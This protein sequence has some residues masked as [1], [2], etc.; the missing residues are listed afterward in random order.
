[1]N[2]MLTLWVAYLSRRTKCQLT[3]KLGWIRLLEHKWIRVYEDE[4]GTKGRTDQQHTLIQNCRENM[5]TFSGF[6]SYTD[7]F[8][9]V[10]MLDM[11]PHRT[12]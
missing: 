12:T 10:L 6:K 9:V 3:P 4:A 8:S 11:I 1:M 7:T 5:I 2:D